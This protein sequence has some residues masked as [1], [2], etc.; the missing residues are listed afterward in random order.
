MTYVHKTAG[1]AALAGLLA[2]C[3]PMTVSPTP[4]ATPVPPTAAPTSFH[5]SPIAPTATPACVEPGRWVEYSYRGVAVA[6]EVPAVIYLPPCYA[7][8]ERRYPTAYFLHGKPFSEQQ[9]VDL[10]LPELAEAA[11]D[12]G[13]PPMILVLARQPEPLFSNSDGG[14]GSYETEFLDGLVAA[15]DE[16]FRTVAQPEGRAV[17]GLSRGGVWALEL[18]LRHPER[19]GAVAALSPALAV[20]YARQ[21][22]DPLHLATTAEPLPGRIWL[23]AGET[24]WARTKTEDLASTLQARGAAPE[25]VLVPGDHGDVTWAALLPDV[26]GFLID[27][28]GPLGASQ[29]AL[30]LGFTMAPD[31]G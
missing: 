26:V 15:V 3:A 18:A 9:W 6:Q 8:D 24:D 16:S 14:P 21:P 20:N 31:A 10:G 13:Q 4:L 28:F 1:L 5:P 11:S 23:G 29:G 22:Y 12:D 27:F 17:V 19:L 30:P 25:F 2:A 7:A